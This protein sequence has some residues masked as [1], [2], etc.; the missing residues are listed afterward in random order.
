MEKWYVALGDGTYAE[1]DGKP[2][3]FL[4][5]DKAELHIRRLGA[6]P[7]CQSVEADRLFRMHIHIK[8]LVEDSHWADHTPVVEREEGI[9][10]QEEIH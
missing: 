3:V 5:T 1:C 4:A 2:F 6:T 7:D 10:I 8:D 9:S